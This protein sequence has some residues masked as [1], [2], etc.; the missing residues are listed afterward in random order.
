MTRKP[1]RKRKRNK[2]KGLLVQFRL[3]PAVGRALTACAAQ[4]DLT[5]GEWVKAH[6]TMACHADQ[7]LRLVLVSEAEPEAQLPLPLAGAGLEMGGQG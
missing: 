5:P 7:V 3:P 2:G 4:C 6:L 1:N